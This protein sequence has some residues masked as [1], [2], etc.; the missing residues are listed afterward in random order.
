MKYYVQ[1]DRFIENH[2]FTST[3]PSYGFANTK[4]AVA[5]STKQKMQ[6]FIDARPNDL[7]C[8]RISR[9]EAFQMAARDGNNNLVLPLDDVID[10][11]VYFVT[12]RKSNY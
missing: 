9:R 12:V 4:E 8:R 10:K 2:N 3:V 5:F 11:C 6:A 7:S 1:Y